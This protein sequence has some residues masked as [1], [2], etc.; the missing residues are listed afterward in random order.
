ML[1]RTSGIEGFA[2][3]VVL[4]RIRAEQAYDERYVS[5]F[6]DEARLAASLH[7]HN[8]VQV[9]DIGQ[10]DGEYFFTMEY[11]HG[12]DARALLANRSQVEEQIP[13]E[14]VMAIGCAAAAGL[15]HAHEQRGPDRK[16]L[17]IVHRDVSPANILIGYDGGVKIVDFGIAKAAQR[18]TKTRT[19][20]LKGKVA[21]MSPEQCVGESVDRR[22]DV[23]SLGI[24]LYELLTVRRLFKNENDFLTMT[25]I[26]LGYIPP[27]STY[28]PD[29]PPELEA[30]VLKALATKPEDRYATA[31]ELRLAL[32]QLAARLQLSMSSTA[33]A[34]YM[35]AVFGTKPEPWLLDDEPEVEI[36][37]D[38]DGSASGIV[39]P[40]ADAM[41]V[42]E[43]REPVRGPRAPSVVLADELR[44]DARNTPVLRGARATAEEWEK[45]WEKE[46][47]EE[48]EEEWED[49]D[50]KATV[51]ASP[52]AVS[53]VPSTVDAESPLIAHAIDESQPIDR[54]PSTRSRR[55]RLRMGLGVT[56]L[57][58]SICAFGGALWM[59]RDRGSE[60][61]PVAIPETL[62]VPS[63]PDK[64][65][66][67]PPTP[68]PTPA[69]EPQL[70]REP[71][72]VAAER[73]GIA[74]P[75]SATPTPTIVP[76]TVRRQDPAIQ[77][78]PQQRRR[79]WD[80][81]ILFIRDDAK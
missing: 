60:P 46:W 79:H 15:H 13:I 67:D 42:A 31:Q 7:H 14:H 38:F 81:D 12:E 22:S 25:S 51:K 6:L 58:A 54:S 18:S 57:V 63:V 16:L 34:D 62:V 66:E 45:E 61:A 11:I 33:L 26:V 41:P 4:K 2:R 24:V 37:I 49:E 50:N 35:K 5:M 29:I 48:W 20:T 73:R 40:P 70:I 21:Y 76:K 36:S 10:S 43:S 39:R 8:I 59:S 52:R 74:T 44:V 56:A 27:L 75:T 80:P 23:F 65:I 68:A 17:D 64:P 28:R 53:E 3:H 47:E 72:P 55:S 78:R 71:A 1:A 30:I 32:E 69:A 77:K 19:G 9:N